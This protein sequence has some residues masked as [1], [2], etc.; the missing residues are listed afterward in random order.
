MSI[1]STFPLITQTKPLSP[2]NNAPGYLP[3]KSFFEY[4]NKTI[5]FNC[6]NEAD[7]LKAYRECPSLK[8]VINRRAQYFVNGKYQILN[9]NTEK[10][11]R[12]DVARKLQMLLDKPNIIQTGKQFKA[13]HNIYL[14]IFGYCPVLKISPAGFPQDTYAM[15]NLPPWLFEVEFKKGKFWTL[16]AEEGNTT[17]D[18][19][20]KFFINW[21]G[22]KHELDIDAVFIVLDNSIGTDKDGNLHLPDSRIKSLEYPISNEMA[23]RMAA[24]TSI[25]RK[26]PNGILSNDPGTGQYIPMKVGAEKE[27]IQNDFKRYGLTGQEWTVIIT[28]AS[29]KWQQMGSPVKDMMLFETITDAQNAICDGMGIY[30][31][32]MAGSGKNTTFANLEEAK[33]S[34]YQDFIIPDDDA[35]TEQLSEGIIPT[36]EKP[37][38]IVDYSHVEVLQQSEQAK[39][40]TEGAKAAAYQAKYD[41]GIVTRNQILKDMGEPE[42]P[43][44][45]MNLY[46]WQ[47]KQPA[48]PAEKIPAQASNQ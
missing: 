6:D 24:N 29:L 3:G 17:K 9:D 18:I 20:N 39:A 38:I 35:R 48:S 27:Q 14:D 42:S 7:Y 22:T 45:E 36:E 44:P 12:G 23:A 5:Y 26:G 28:D 21:E 34:Q 2:Y 32:L 40:V 15:W 16:A 10:P 43:L 25:T 13:Q 19:Y 11:L 1:L 4:G 47:Q 46:S 31:F 33:K 41:L 30:T 37:Y 8:A